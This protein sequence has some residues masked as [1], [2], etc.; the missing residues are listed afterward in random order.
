MTSDQVNSSEP[1]VA[2][3]QGGE[4]KIAAESQVIYM[5][6]SIAQQDMQRALAYYHRLTQENPSAENLLKKFYE[7]LLNMFMFEDLLAVTN[8]RLRRV[9][10]CA[11][12]VSWK[13]QALQHMFRNEEAVELLEALAR[14]N[15]ENLAT[16]NLLGMYQRDIGDFNAANKSFSK[17][18]SI[19]PAF[20]PAYWNRSEYSDDPE[21]DL[22]AVRAAIANPIIKESQSHYLQFSAYRFC[23]KLELYEEAFEHLQIAN[24][25]KRR[26]FDYNVKHDIQADEKAKQVFSQERINQFASDTNSNLRPIFIM[27]MP[28]SGTTLVEQIIASHSDVAG[29][30]EFTALA[31]ASMRA[32]L[33]SDYPGSVDQWLKNSSNEDYKRL[34]S[35]YADNM[36]FIRKGKKIFTDKNQYNHRSIGLI[37]ASMP[38]AK[39]ILI[40]RQAM[41]VGFGCYRQLFG[42]FG[43]KFSY[44][45]DEIAPFY[46]SYM[47]LM[48]YW[49][50]VTDGLILRIR[51]EDLVQ[52][53]ETTSKKLLS[54]CE[55]DWQD[56]CLNFHQ[57]KRTVKTL[58]SSQV[59]QPIFKQGVDRWKRYESQLA[60]LKKEFNRVGVRLSG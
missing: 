60:P 55:L 13:L 26:S 46:K 45:I 31:N 38:N 56:N 44:K 43:A 54:F 57:T 8:D 42:E 41:D 23:E 16:L 28:R 3:T 30:D 48:D 9:P 22:A 2:Y 34:A 29:G 27:G 59:R 21:T 49:E 24:A 17:A 1:Q 14:G 19:N 20:A 11:V 58:S 6:E 5:L 52:N 53:Q 15:P 47:A 39:I 18:I 25:M 4:R 40:E 12:S 37:K 50:S 35:F 36:R 10:G 32:Q 33:A 7:T 51:Y